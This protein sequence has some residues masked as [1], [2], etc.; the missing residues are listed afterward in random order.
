[1]AH[2]DTMSALSVASTIFRHVSLLQTFKTTISLSELVGSQDFHIH[3]SSDF[4]HNKNIWDSVSGQ[5]KLSEYQLVTLAV[6]LKLSN[7]SDIPPLAYS[8]KGWIV[9][10]CT[11]WESSLTL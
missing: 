3:Q 11:R 9:G 6:S 5:W 8:M 10:T 7:F 1:M 2:S 4:A